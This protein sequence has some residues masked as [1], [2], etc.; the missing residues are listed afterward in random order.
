MKQVIV[1][2]QTDNKRAVLFH[3]GRRA[4]VAPRDLTP[5][6]ITTAV[7]LLQ[8]G[9]LRLLHVGYTSK[10]NRTCGLST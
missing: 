8:P 9:C 6:I 2:L 1:P 3:T 7:S 4:V 5:N 10:I